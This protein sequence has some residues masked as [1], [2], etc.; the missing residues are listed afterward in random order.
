MSEDEFAGGNSALIAAG[1]LAGDKLASQI[2]L[3]W[4]KAAKVSGKVEILIK[5]TSDLGS[6]VTLR[7]ALQDVPGVSG[8]RIEQMKADQATLSVDYDRDSHALAESLMRRSFE[9]FGVDIYELEN[10]RLRLEIVP[11]RRSPSHLE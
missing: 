4:K 6:Y 5:G 10:N 9:N 8:L 7:R 3:T 2:A 11:A 1:R